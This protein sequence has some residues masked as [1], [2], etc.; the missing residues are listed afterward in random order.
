MHQR[1]LIAIS[2]I[3]ACAL[4]TGASGQKVYRCGNTYSQTPCGGDKT[5]DTTSPNATSAAARRQAVDKENKRQM[6][7]AK[8]MEKAR[9]AQE[10]EALKRHQAELK[11]IEEEKTKA[12]K[13]AT[14]AA[15]STQAPLK[16]K[17]PPEFFTAKEA[18]AAKP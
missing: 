6:E 10:A 13:G 7:A 11:A 16:N 3:A 4:S 18:P 17:K 8:A 9:L 15:V 1:L 12:A 14:G 2:F 5:L